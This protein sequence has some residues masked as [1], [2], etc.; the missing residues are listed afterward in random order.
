MFRLFIIIAL[1]ITSCVFLSMEYAW[2]IHF[3]TSM[4]SKNTLET[5]VINMHIT[6]YIFDDALDSSQSFQNGSQQTFPRP[7]SFHAMGKLKTSGRG[8]KSRVFEAATV[9][10]RRGEKLVNIEVQSSPTPQSLSRNASPSKKR[11]WSPGISQDN[12]DDELPSMQP[13]KRS[14]KSGKVVI[15]VTIS[16][17]HSHTFIQTQNEFLED[18]LSSRNEILIEILKHES[19]PLARSCTSC[20]VNPGTY[21]CKD[22]F[23]NH[24]ICGVCCLSSHRTAPFHRIQLFNGQYFENSDLD[25]LGLVIDVRNHSHECIP[26]SSFM[27]NT[28]TSDH[29]LSEDEDHLSEAFHESSDPSVAGQSANQPRGAFISDR[30][31]DR[32]GSDLI[33]VSSTGIFKRQ[34]QWCQ[35]PNKPAPFVQL[36]RSKLF[37]ASF[38]RPETA[39]TFEVLDHFHLD[40]LECKTA[41]MNFMSKIVRISNEAFPGKIPVHIPFLQIALNAHSI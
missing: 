38:N 19:P 28:P 33:C 36:L 8:R 4:T 27:Q 14:R 15:C 13:P 39:F 26:R 10:T 20:T 2:Q 25:D 3:R 23:T 40:A 1:K 24:L 32:T 31:G 5:C 6:Q 34:V 11:V 35:C 9:H 7:N 16:Q 12:N 17:Q 30:H 37:P 18:Y 21:R 29:H 41:A 22:C